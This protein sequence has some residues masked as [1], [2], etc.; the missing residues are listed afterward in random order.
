M[1][2]SIRK[3]LTLAFL[4][5]AVGPLLLVGLILTMK[6][7]SVQKQEAVVLQ[8]EVASHI[9]SRVLAFMK[10]LES[11]LKMIVQVQN[12]QT[13]DWD[14]QNLILS[15]LHARQ[16][17]FDELILLDATGRETIFLSRL[18]VNND[19]TRGQQADTDA[20][21]VPMS[22]SVTYY[23]PVRFKAETGE[24]LMIMSVPLLNLL[25]GSPEG[26]LVAD[27][28]IKEIWNLV[29]RLRPGS[30]GNS[31]IVDSKDRVVAHRNPSVVFRGTQ[32]DPPDQDGIH[33]GLK[34]EK[35]VLVSE[36]IDLGEQRFHI[37]VENPVSEAMGGCETPRER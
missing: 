37:V 9:S 19:S 11:E 24:P 14:Q 15:I 2:Q 20:F 7:Y 5:L 17:A 31:Y 6:T 3:R 10:E 34:G 33:L 29:A 23:G 36:K 26:V 28:R 30:K 13:L 8:R 27:V 21:R 32:F 16:P 4:A 25:T 1:Q 22:K 35:A 18:K 12:F